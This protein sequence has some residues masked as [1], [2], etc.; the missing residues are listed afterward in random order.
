MT[1]R[2]KAPAETEGGRVRGA[3][4][5]RLLSVSA[6]PAAVTTTAEKVAQTSMVTESRLLFTARA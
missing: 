2:K 5:G 3:C 1:P 4:A 6:V